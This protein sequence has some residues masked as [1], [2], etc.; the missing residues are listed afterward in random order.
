MK[1]SVRASLEGRS[2]GNSPNVTEQV[3]FRFH[4]L[5]ITS[6]TLV[7]HFFEENT[8]IPLKEISSY[9]SKWH[10]HDPT[11]AKKYWFLVLT[12]YLENGD[13]RSGTI[14]V[15]KFNYVNDEHEL[16]QH[17]QTNIALP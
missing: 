10:L 5:E 1:T 4:D 17:I 13:E 3:A 11:F 6:K 15:M 9:H 8:V 12:V 2:S 14:A 7:M 16:R